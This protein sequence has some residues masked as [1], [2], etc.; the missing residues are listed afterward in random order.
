MESLTNSIFVMTYGGFVIGGVGALKPAARAHIEANRDTKYVS[1]LHAQQDLN[2][3]T[4][5]AFV[6]RGA[7]WA[8][9]VGG[10]TALFRFDCS[11]EWDISE[12]KR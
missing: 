11:R 8:W 7:R 3:A 2:N 9:K 10:F 12:G 4:L 5:K 6:R 1:Q